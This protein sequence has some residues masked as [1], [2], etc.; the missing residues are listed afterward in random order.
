MR[1]WIIS[2]DNGLPMSQVGILN[3]FWVKDASCYCKDE[4]VWSKLISVESLEEIR[5]IK[6]H[7]KV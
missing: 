5:G 6:T 2:Q 7:G 1:V 4:I 3:L